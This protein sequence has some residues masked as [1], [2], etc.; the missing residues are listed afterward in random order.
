MS[1]AEVSVEGKSS[2][3]WQGGNKE[4]TRLKTKAH[5]TRPYWYWFGQG[6]LG[7][8]LVWLA[9][10]GALVSGLLLRIWMLGRFPQSVDGDSMVYGTL[11]KNLLVHGQFALTDGSGVLHAT[12]IRLPGYPLLLALIF[13][14]F[15]VG[16]YAA[17][18]VVQIIV[19][20]A[21]CLLLADFVRL[22]TGRLLPA[23]ITL[24]LAALCPFTAIYAGAP[25]TE[26]PTLFTI[27]LALWSTIRFIQTPTAR[28]GR[29]SGWNS[30]WSYAL[31]FAAA[32][33]AAAMLRPD[34]ALVAFALAPALLLGAG[35]AAERSSWRRLATMATVCTVL[36]LLPFAVWTLRNWRALH[37][38]QPLAPRYATD[39]G[40]DLFPGWQ[41]WVKTWCLD[42]VSTEQVYWNVPDGV[43]NPQQLPDRAFDSAAQQQE[44]VALVEEYNQMQQ[45]TPELDARFAHLAEE[46]VRAHPLRFYLG[47]PLGRVADMWLR[48]RVENM[49]IES[50]WWDFERHQE[51]TRLCWA[52]VGLN[53]FYLLLGV[54]GLFLRPRLWLAMLA[55]FLLRSALLATIEAP[56]ARYTLEC[57]PML[58]IL[59][60]VA[61]SHG[62]YWFQLRTVDG[63]Q[64]ALTA[65]AAAQDSARPD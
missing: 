15:G 34:G 8:G 20:L 45:L 2:G 55:Y 44:T 59:G 17:V 61:L 50:D 62:L 28:L 58:F 37:V 60:G 12:L 27:A 21:S 43:L 36:A 10:A 3:M 18:A 35:R 1:V 22:A 53:L 13:S 29:R 57:F 16:N 14:L 6:R 38:I 41:R 11:A 31:L 48:P 54:A 46:R 30:R 19:D 40:E 23:L 49:P 63:R 47:L 4:M 9:V 5:W 64:R 51:E 52:Y 32:V 7:S 26:T 65:N 39:P 56:E 33:S 25:L 42:F 24:W